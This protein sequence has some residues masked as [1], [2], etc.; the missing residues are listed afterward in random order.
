M[1]LPLESVCDKS[2]DFL[3]LIQEEHDSHISNTLIIEVRAGDQL[4]AL[5]LA[6]VCRVPQHVYEL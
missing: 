1:F 6:K 3:A 2:E 5:H 4:Q